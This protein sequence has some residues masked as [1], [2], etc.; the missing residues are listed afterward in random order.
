MAEAGDNNGVPDAGEP[1]IL[2]HAALPEGVRSR[3]MP[4]N[5][6][7]FMAYN[8]SGFARDTVVGT[9]FTGIVLCDSRGNQRLG[10]AARNSSAA[11]ALVVSPTGRPE[12]TRNVTRI[13]AVGACP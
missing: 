7:G 9:R 12:V 10:N 2:A 4:A 5:N 8:A 1:V 3:P 13:N 6:G 11:R